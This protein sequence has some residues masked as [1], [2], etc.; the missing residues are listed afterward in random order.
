MIQLDGKV[1]DLG[2]GFQ[3]RRVLPQRQQRMVGPFIFL[4]H[5]GP[6]IKKPDQNIDVRPHPHIGLST[7]TYLFEGRSVHR[8]SLGEQIVILP[9]DVNLM[10]AGLGIVHSERSH[11][12]DRAIAQSIHGLQFW[13]ALPD[14]LEDCEPRFQN[15]P[16]S[17]IPVDE[18]EDRIISI[19]VGSA[20][21]QKSPVHESSPTL[22]LDIQAKNDFMFAN[23]NPE[24]QIGFY[25]VSGRVYHDSNY[26]NQNQ[27]MIFEPNEW[28]QLKIEKGSRIAVLGGLKFSTTRHMWWNFVSS[29]KEK[30]E[31]AK[32]RWKAGRFPKVPNE[33]E[34]IPLPEN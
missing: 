24:F 22:F 23:T 12:D 9:G 20:F 13:I 15:C 7:L 14:D 1:H 3:V 17:K 30:I 21:N 4:D 28:S 6:I 26:I 19:V 11:E 29:S 34:F 25:V 10:T 31:E 32:K 8:D 27:I 5:M 2:G 33:T 18:N 16:K